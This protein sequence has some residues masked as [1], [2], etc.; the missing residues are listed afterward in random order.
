MMIYQILA[1]EKNHQ[2]NKSCIT[3]DLVR[4]NPTFFLKKIFDDQFNFVVNL[5]IRTEKDPFWLKK[6][7]H[8]FI[9]ERIKRLQFMESFLDD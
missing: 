7:D 2:H 4:K 8:E 6:L 1:I 3:S 5:N 9:Q